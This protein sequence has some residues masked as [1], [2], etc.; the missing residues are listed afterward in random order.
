MIAFGFLWQLNR[1]GHLVFY[2]NYT[3]FQKALGLARQAKLA[4]GLTMRFSVNHDSIVEDARGRYQVQTD[5][6]G[7][8]TFTADLGGGHRGVYGYL[9]SNLPDQTLAS[10]LQSANLN[11]ELSLRQVQENWYQFY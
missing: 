7:H 9:F 3:K 10:L 8:Y 5:G 1:T 2:A 4:P 11:P 6:Q